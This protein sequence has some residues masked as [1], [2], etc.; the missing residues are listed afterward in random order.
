MDQPKANVFRQS[1]GAGPSMPEV[2]KRARAAMAEINDHPIDQ[3]IRCDRTEEGWIV[4]VEVIESPA[5]MGE[6]DFLAAFSL[7]LDASGALM[8]VDRI[9]RYRR[10]D[11][12]TA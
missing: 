5:R 9:G 2:I 1:K 6:N 3:V 4:V 8:G 10:E 11:G 12:R 7:A